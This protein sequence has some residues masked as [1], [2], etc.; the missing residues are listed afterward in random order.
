MS[1]KAS[2]LEAAGDG[3]VGA[4]GGFAFDELAEVVEMGV[5]LLAAAVARFWQCCLTKERQR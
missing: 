2:G 4:Q 1:G 5:L 3:A